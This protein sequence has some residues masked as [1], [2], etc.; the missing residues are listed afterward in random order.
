MKTIFIVLIVAA[1]LALLLIGGGFGISKLLMEETHSCST[2]ICGDNEQ[3]QESDD[4]TFSC[5]CLPNVCFNITTQKC[6]SIKYR[7]IQYGSELAGK[8]R[9]AENAKNLGDVYDIIRSVYINGD[10]LPCNVILDHDR[11]SLLNKCD[12]FNS[13]YSEVL[14]VDCDYYKWI[15]SSYGTVPDNAIEGGKRGDETVYICRTANYVGWMQ[16]SNASCYAFTLNKYDSTYDL[17]T[18]GN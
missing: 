16:P 17:L 1:C 15:K 7:W 12:Y 11:S 4:H 2:I 9:I 14:F 18:Y 8:M 6:E 13:Q 5:T 3:C 10:K